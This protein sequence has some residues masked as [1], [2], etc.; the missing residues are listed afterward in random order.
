MF[1]R[2]GHGQRKENTVLKGCPRKM[3]QYP[4]DGGNELRANRKTRGENG[5]GT[6]EREGESLFPNSSNVK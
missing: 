5:T 4:D 6:E 3:T 2:E 1:M